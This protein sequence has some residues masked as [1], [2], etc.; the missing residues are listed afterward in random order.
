MQAEPS[1]VDPR[2]S[3]QVCDALDSCLLKNH[4][5][6]SVQ[7]LI[8]CDDVLYG[9]EVIQNKDVLGT[10]V[11]SENGPIYFPE[12]H[13]VRFAAVSQMSFTFLTTTLHCAND[14]FAVQSAP[15]L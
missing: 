1:V 9:I 14:A 11:D 15:I 6:T 12:S 2:V 8:F 5:L 7:N 13:I 10:H 4:V 3:V